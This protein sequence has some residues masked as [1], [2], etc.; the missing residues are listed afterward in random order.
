MSTDAIISA[1]VR[2]LPEYKRALLAVPDKLRR[3][4]LRN[5]LA[6]G[7]RL[8]RDAA[9]VATPVLA[10]PI[11]R[12]GQLIRKPGTVRDA[13]AVRTS[14]E[15][16][17]AGNVG[18]FV[19]VRPAKGAKYRTAKGGGSGSAA[20]RRRVLVKAGGRGAYSPT[21]PFYWR[22]LEWGARGAPGARML[23]RGAG[24]LGQAVAVV[25]G[26]LAVAIRKLDAGGDL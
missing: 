15:S 21:D 5:A 19:N 9:R 18:V 1:T 25:N 23:Q 14:K 13:I 2:N 8:V 12:R 4:V 24:R 11:R 17:A 22:W 7:A 3:R 6:A 26:R 10:A 16:K 20:V